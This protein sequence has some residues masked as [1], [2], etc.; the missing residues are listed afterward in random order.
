VPTKKAKREAAITICKLLGPGLITGTADD[1]S[2]GIA[3]SSLGKPLLP[4]P[5][6]KVQP[7]DN[8]P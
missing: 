7:L 2:S 8:S 4:E 6:E 5:L 3:N 1:D